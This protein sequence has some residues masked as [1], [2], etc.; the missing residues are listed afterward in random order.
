[1]FISERPLEAV[2]KRENRHLG[3][4]CGMIRAPVP[5]ILSTSD[6]LRSVFNDPR[7]QPRG[8]GIADWRFVPEGFGLN[9]FKQFCIR[10]NEKQAEKG[11]PPIKMDGTFRH[12]D[13]DAYWANRVKMYPAQG[14]VLYCSLDRVMQ[15][16]NFDG[17]PYGLDYEAK[18]AWAMSR[19]GSGLVSVEQACYLFARSAIETGRPLW[20]GRVACRNNYGSHYMFL[21]CSARLGVGFGIGNISAEKVPEYELAI[22]EIFVGD[23]NTRR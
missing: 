16:K 19:E 11:L 12:R 13:L 4:L 23:K 21:S 14:G 1:M 6:T 8:W 17:E 18:H 9:A 22:P 2:V 5:S 20:Q 15:P 7:F 10:F 3:A